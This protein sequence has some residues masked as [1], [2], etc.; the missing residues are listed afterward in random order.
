MMFKL[1]DCFLPS[2]VRTILGK[3]ETEGEL[4]QEELHK[5]HATALSFAETALSYLKKW[6]EKKLSGPGMLQLG[7]LE[8]NTF[9][10]RHRKNFISCD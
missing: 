6:T 2:A 7:N 3:P 9:M 1:E 4:P 10:D 8:Q 5:F